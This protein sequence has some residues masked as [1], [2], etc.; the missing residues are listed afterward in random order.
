MRRAIQICAATFILCLTAM[1]NDLTPGNLILVQDNQIV[2]YTPSGSV[3]QSIAVPVSSSPGE[4]VRD[5]IVT[6]TGNIA[7]YNGTFDPVLSIYDPLTG[8]WENT[9]FSGWSTVNNGS[10]GGISAFS[11]FVYVTDMETGGSGDAPRG[12]VR[13]NTANNSAQRFAENSD[14]IDLTI[15]FDNLLYALD[16]NQYSVSV[17]DPVSFNLLR[18]LSLANNCRGIAVNE[19]GTIFGASWD[20]NVYRFASSGSMLDSLNVGFTLCDIDLSID[21]QLAVVTR[22]DGAFLTDGNLTAI[23]WITSSDVDF[24]A[25]TTPVPEPAT[26]LLIALGSAFLRKKALIKYSRG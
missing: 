18:T 3:I 14:F 6:P 2:E 13:F 26:L 16:R 9:T 25:F 1:G 8:T 20:E 19:H 17:Y 23:N 4:H 15:G 24:V 12:I 10:Y 7:V 5:I 22:L 21:G 11:D